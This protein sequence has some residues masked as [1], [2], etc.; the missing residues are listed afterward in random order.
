MLGEYHQASLTEKDANKKLKWFTRYE[1]KTSPAET[2]P[3]EETLRSS[4]KKDQDILKGKN[5]ISAV[6][7]QKTAIKPKTKNN[8]KEALNLYL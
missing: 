6:K 4:T 5:E 1:A 8:L 3:Q 2:K 7:P